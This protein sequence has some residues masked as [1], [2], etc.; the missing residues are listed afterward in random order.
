MCARSSASDEQ[1]QVA[2]LYD[3]LESARMIVAY[4]DGLSR[5]AFIADPRTR[6]A[7][8]LRLSII[9]EAA[10]HVS[11]TTAA[12]LPTI[13]FRQIRGLRNRITHDYG[14]VDPGIVWEVARHDLAPLIAALARHLHGVLPPS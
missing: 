7:V 12:V 4:M 8:A 11:E 5:E 2:Y 9:G 10:G 14:Q 6:D 3:M 1:R 13:P